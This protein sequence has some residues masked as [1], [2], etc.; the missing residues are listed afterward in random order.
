[1]SCPC[2]T[3]STGQK[4]PL[5]GLGTWKSAPGQV[6]QA[7]LS[8]LDCGYRHIDCAAAYGNEQ[9]VGEALTERVGPGKVLRR[10][11]VFVTSKLWNTQHHPDD[12]ESACRLSLAHLGLDYLDLYLMHWP[13][14]FQ[15]GTEV[16]PRNADG[17]IRYADTHYRDT[18]KAMEALVDLGLVKAIGLSNFNARQIDDVLS[19]ANH[20]PVVNQVECHPYLIQ[21][22][23]L[24]HCGE[25][26]VLVTAYSPL[27]SPDRPWATPG[28][29]LLLEDPQVL[30]I[31]SR[32]GKSP[33]QVIIRWQVQRGVIC[34]PKSITPSRIQQNIQVF[35][36]KLS[37]EDMKQIE[38][39]NKN[40]RLIIPTIERDGQKVWRDAVHPHFPFHD[41]C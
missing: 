40:E 30:D 20:K 14:A 15:R 26:G 16:M 38:S 10:E 21:A 13:M 11:D 34:I 33:A 9:E 8:A 41:P 29:P 19:M 36:F 25:R 7:V 32:N 39:F 37:D 3:L 5:V 17:S 1:M 23:L 31:A 2:V 28:E 24:A 18:W 27:G 35:D 4:M 6:K 22:Q 12:V